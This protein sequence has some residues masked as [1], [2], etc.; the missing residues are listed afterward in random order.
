VIKSV[1]VSVIALVGAGTNVNA[2]LS[3]VSPSLVLLHPE[4]ESPAQV[5]RYQSVALSGST[6]ASGLFE[7]NYRDERYLPFEGCG[8]GATWELEMPK[9]SNRFDFGSLA[10]V[11]IT[12][13]Y[14]A[15]FDRDLKERVIERLGDGTGGMLPLT[16]RNSFPDAWYHFHNPVFEPEDTQVPE[17][18]PYT[19]VLRTSRPMFP[20]NESD[21]RLES[22]A[23]SFALRDGGSRV[24]VRVRFTSDIGEELDI[25]RSTGPGGYLS[26]EDGFQGLLPFGTWLI[27]LERDRAPESLWARDGDGAPIMENISRSPDERVVL[28]TDQLIDVTFALS[29]SA[30][31]T[32]PPL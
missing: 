24:P 13:D 6:N 7:L 4:D 19:L 5:P 27:E 31:L 1:R 15:L 8:V 2:T 22:A 12:I 21:Q 23:L 18:R 28:D 30:R 3:M 10:D 17:S 20:P 11:L 9:P 32:W 25:R 26:L 14:T 16:V 29:Y